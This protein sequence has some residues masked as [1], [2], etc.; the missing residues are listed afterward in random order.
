[1]ASPAG[2]RVNAITLIFTVV[3][4]AAVALRLITRIAVLR[5]AG[6][7]D[8]CITLAMVRQ[9]TIAASLSAGNVNARSRHSP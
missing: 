4:A 3:A 7:E 6:F 5:N 1:M 9:I 2:Y 8:V